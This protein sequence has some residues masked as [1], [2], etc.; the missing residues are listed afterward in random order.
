MS[1]ELFSR[2]FLSEGSMSGEYPFSLLKEFRV[3]FG[4]PVS[5]ILNLMSWFCNSYFLSYWSS[6]F[7]LNVFP[8]KLSYYYLKALVLKLY[9]VYH[10]TFLRYFSNSWLFLL[11]NCILFHWMIDSSCLRTLIIFRELSSVFFI[12]LFN[13]GF[14]F[15]LIFP[16]HV[17]AYF[18]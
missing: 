9:F 1:W 14:L 18:K 6:L 15:I 4:I 11:K 3:F 8:G 2:S 12:V 13:S 7:L 16:F 17:E 5:Q 10:F